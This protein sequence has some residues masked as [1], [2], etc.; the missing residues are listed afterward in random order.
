M[1][2]DR[3]SLL[4]RLMLGFVGVTSA[5]WFA[6][7]LVVIWQALRMGDDQQHNAMRTY[8]RQILA[9]ATAFAADPEHLTQALDKVQAIE[10][11]N[12][13][14]DDDPGMVWLQVW[15]A[16]VHLGP[17][18]QLPLAVPPVEPEQQRFEHDGRVYNAHVLHDQDTAMVVRV[19][20]PRR[21]AFSLMWPSAGFVFVPLLLSLPLLLVPAWFTLRSGLAPLRDVVGTIEGRVRELELSPMQVPVHRELKPL[22]QAVNELMARLRAQLVRERGFLAD[23]A[24]GMKTPLAIMQANLDIA[25]GQAQSSV[26]DPLDAKQRRDAALRDLDAGIARADRLTRQL[27]GMSRLDADDRRGLERRLD[28]AEFLRERVALLVPVADRR[29]LTISVEAPD[30]HSIT[31]DPDAVGAIV[32]NLL[33]NAIKYSPAGGHIR[34][35]LDAEPARVVLAIGDEGPGIPEQA[36]DD[37]FLRFRR[38]GTDHDD[39][40]GQSVGLGLA[41]VRRAVERLGGT[42]S[43]GPHAAA[44]NAAGDRCPPPDAG[45]GLLVR[46]VLPAD[47][48]SLRA[49]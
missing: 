10:V 33:E 2:P 38:V 22:V 32:D 26:A 19:S 39:D 6:V 5:L 24:H 42:I 48:T 35:A 13:R 17:G 7:A 4:R 25:R 45:P 23:V 49:A 47:A 43:M 29:R 11:E 46:V 9:A 44:G 28:L 18:R 36:I 40:A 12:A 31:V 21:N 16:G 27:L 3:R 1:K 20:M 34:V 41:I 15:R 30:S 37:A 14:G 8:A